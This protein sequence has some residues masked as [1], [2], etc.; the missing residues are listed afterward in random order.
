MIL[1]LME[2]KMCQVFVE[3]KNEKGHKTS[4]GKLVKEFSIRRLD[5]LTKEDLS[6][7]AQR[8]AMASGTAE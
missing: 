1:Q 3:K 2:E 4:T 8:Q 6:A 7:L 5:A